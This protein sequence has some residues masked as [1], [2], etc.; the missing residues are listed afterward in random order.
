MFIAAL[1]YKI[2]YIYY[3]ITQKSKQPK[4][5]A[6]NEWINKMMYHSHMMKYY[7][8]IKRNKVPIYATTWMNLENITL[9]ERSQSQKTTY[10]M[11]P[12]I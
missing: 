8:I 1:Y 2:L 10:Y 6:T 7:S 5:S 12:F 9:S 11:I 3:I 4:C